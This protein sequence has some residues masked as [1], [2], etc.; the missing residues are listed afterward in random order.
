MREE[1][2]LEQLAREL[3]QILAETW[4][5]HEDLREIRRHTDI[6]R[7][8]FDAIDLRFDQLHQWIHREPNGFAAAIRQAFEGSNIALREG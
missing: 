6:V 2:T 3:D 5:A 7:Q 8:Q 1:V 4:A